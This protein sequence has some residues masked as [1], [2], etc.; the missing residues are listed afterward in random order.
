MQIKTCRFILN[1]LEGAAVKNNLPAKPKIR[2]TILFTKTA[3]S[4]NPYT[5]EISLNKCL[6]FRLF[7]PIVRKIIKHEVKHIEQFQIMARYFAGLAENAD[8]GLKNFKNFLL[9]KNSMNECFKFNEK[10]YKQT[11]AKDGKITK[12]H[13]LFEKAKEYVQALKEYPDLSPLDDLEV[14]YQKGFKE[15]IK[16][17]RQKKKLYKNNLL[18]KE[19]RAAAKAK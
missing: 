17:K 19:A 6:N 4:A 12:S 16:S 18:E 10:F 15:M 5:A 2:S 11:I 3:G 9:Q 1:T 13:P 7:R 8:K 14:L